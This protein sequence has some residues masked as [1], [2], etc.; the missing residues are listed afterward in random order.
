MA[1]SSGI[2]LNLLVTLG[3]LLE[4]RNLTRAGAKLNL[5]QPT[6]SGALA[7]LR[8]HFGDELLVRCGGRYSLT[9]MAERLL[10][11]VQQALH[12]VER[13]FNADGE[14]DPRTSTRRF[15]LAIAG[16]SIVLLS[17]L[18]R[19]VHELAPGIRL[20]TSPLTPELLDGDRGLLRHDL[21]IAPEGALPD[22][23]PDVIGRDKFV[24]VL[25]PANP[26]LRDGRLSTDD[27]ATMPHAMPLFPGAGMDPVGP[28]LVRLG[29][30]PKV[31]VTTMGWLALPFV[32]AGTDMVA[33]VPE[34]LAFRFG[35]A[36]GV[37]VT[38]VPFGVIELVHAAWWH[39]L[40]AAD[41]ALAWLRG[42]LR[43]AAEALS[44]QLPLPRT[45]ALSASR[46]GGV[47]IRPAR[48]TSK[49]ISYAMSP[50]SQLDAASTARLA[51][52]LIDMTTSTPACISTTVWMT[53][54]PSNTRAEPW[55]RL[56]SPEVTAAS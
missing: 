14:F 3:A 29:I 34:G 25:D 16:H 39:P 15:S 33:M 30:T 37:T 41:P 31:A 1:S 10:P 27:L 51:E 36:A 40:A 42:V 50:R 18:L 24:C 28:A 45:A 17:T 35:E 38:E 13:T 20:E 47:I 11:A 44:R 23:R 56:L 12:Q 5:S 55:V 49:V 9:P 6:M 53:M 54:P 22:C 52:E 8:R 4:E 19:R 2:D 21:L 26:R 7:R 32:V 43:Q 46:T 48:S